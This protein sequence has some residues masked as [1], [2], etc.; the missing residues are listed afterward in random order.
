MRTSCGGASPTKPQVT[1][2][3]VGNVTTWSLAYSLI[4]PHRVGGV[5]GCCGF[6]CCGFVVLLC[7]VG[8]VVCRDGWRLAVGDRSRRGVVGRWRWQDRTEDGA[9]VAGGCPRAVVLTAGGQ[10]VVACCSSVAC[11]DCNVT[12]SAAFGC[13]FEA[14]TS[15]SSHVFREILR[16]GLTCVCGSCSLSHIAARESAARERKRENMG[17]P[18]GV[19]K[20]CDEPLWAVDGYWVDGTDGDCCSGDDHLTNENE[21]HVP[22]SNS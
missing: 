3:T 21:P 11:R 8:C 20:Y 4:E 19:C 18:D 16:N 17:F 12:L 9:D 22:Q 7:L 6:V 2:V 15:W 1:T 14:Q 13:P 5:C 10:R